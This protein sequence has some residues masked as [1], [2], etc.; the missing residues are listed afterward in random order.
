MRV[1]TPILVSVGG[2]PTGLLAYFLLPF[3]NNLDASQYYCWAHYT[4]VA[5]SHIPQR[6]LIVLSWFLSTL[7][8]ALYT[9]I[10][11]IEEIVLKGIKMGRKAKK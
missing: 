5:V 10:C 6:D 9:Y 2:N 4:Y 7:R 1:Y 3:S 8:C 11:L